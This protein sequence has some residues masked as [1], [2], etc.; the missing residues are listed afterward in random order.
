AR[1]RRVPAVVGLGVDLTELS[2]HALVDAHRGVLIV[3]PGPAARAQFERDARSAS[4]ARAL[5]DAAALRPGATLDGTP[6]RVMLNIADPAELIGLDPAICDGIGLVRTELLFHD[7]RGLPA[8]E[9]QY[10]VYRRI[11]E[12]A[13]DRPVTIRTLDA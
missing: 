6:I 11:A 2:G 1:S 7:Q 4:T 9:D 13:Q 12:W 5:T 10:A 8:E 3:N